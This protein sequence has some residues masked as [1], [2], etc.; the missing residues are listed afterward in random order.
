LLKKVPGIFLGDDYIKPTFVEKKI[1]SNIK[2]LERHSIPTGLPIA[3]PA[4]L[5]IDLIYWAFACYFSNRIF[6]PLPSNLPPTE[7]QTL[8]ASLGTHIIIQ[9]NTISPTS[10]ASNTQTKMRSDLEKVFCLIFTSGSSSGPRAVALTRDNFEASAKIHAKIHG[11]NPNDVWLCNLPLFHIGGLSIPFRAYF[12]G[13]NFAYSAEPYQNT[14]WENITHTSMVPTSLH[15]IF[16]NH[17]IT[18]LSKLKAILLGGAPASES[19]LRL[20]ENAKLPLLTTYGLTE[21]SSQIVTTPYA[22]PRKIFDGVGQPTDDISLKISTNGI[23]S[24]KGGVVAAGYWNGGDIKKITDDDGYFSTND[25]GK[26][27]S[28][29]VLHILGRNDHTVISGGE[30]IFPQEVENVLSA[31]PNIRACAVVGV[32]DPEWGEKLVAAIELE[33]EKNCPSQQNLRDFLLQKINP[34]KIPKVFLFV[35]ALPKSAVGKIIRH[36]VGDLFKKNSP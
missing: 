17:D 28:R 14:F 11:D 30:N 31:H 29:G 25:L 9:K 16:K 33:D 10:L 23:I 21:S 19:L 32:A 35:S 22:F 5:G 36:K 34:R 18:P 1:Y 26:I 7:L 12:L 4:T 24:I 13:Q 27:D 2:L 8:T 20:G 3:I 15:R 6:V